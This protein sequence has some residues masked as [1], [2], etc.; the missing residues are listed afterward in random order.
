MLCRS[1]LGVALC[2]PVSAQSNSP[3][4]LDRYETG[5]RLR[6]FERAL[7]AAPDGPERTAALRELE[8]AVQAF[9]GLD[10]AQVVR[11]LDRAS[12][13]LQ[14]RTPPRDERWAAGLRVV[15]EPRLVAA[16]TEHATIWL[17]MAYDAGEAVPDGCLLS[18]RQ[19]GAD[20]PLW[21][22]P[23]GALPG[24]FRLPLGALPLGDLELRARITTEARVLAERPVFL[25]RIPDLATR[26]E[27][28]DNAPGS[29]SDDAAEAPRAQALERHTLAWHLELLRGMTTARREETV[30][31]AV[32]LLETAEAL[33]AAVT[34]RRNH[35]EGNRFGQF[36][37]RVPVGQTTV[38][39]RWFAPPPPARAPERRP[40]VVALHG[41]GGSENLFFDGYG[42]GAI[43]ELARARG[44]FVLAPRLGMLGA[45]DVAALVDAL[46]ERWPIDRSRV[47]L[48]GHSMG[49]AAAVSIACRKPTRYAA[50]AALGGGGNVLKGAELGGLSWYVGAGERDFGRAGAVALHQRL[51]ALGVPAKYREFPAVEHLAIVQFALPEVFEHF[52]TAFAAR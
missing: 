18:L 44:W 3:P 30:L 24:V 49:A 48:L 41:A 2:L 13:A 20:T 35:Y 21:S 43:V 8:A 39:V 27:R 28:I 26:L 37:L 22:T 7:G 17:A 5:L 51:Q 40:L 9:F 47:A 38:P 32:S 10:L 1:A 23:I 11:R 16:T 33:A 25:A 29:T 50:V 46:A 45:P 31:P 42:D 4:P 12:W 14:A 19:P 15:L 52:A 6:A 34:A 36:W